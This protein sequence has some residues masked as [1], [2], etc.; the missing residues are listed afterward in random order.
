MRLAGGAGTECRSLVKVLALPGLPLRNSTKL[1][2]II[3]VSVIPPVGEM[4][5][6]PPPARGLLCHCSGRL[7]SRNNWFGGRN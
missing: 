7:S 1:I 4:S 2:L 3:Q 6:S 5:A